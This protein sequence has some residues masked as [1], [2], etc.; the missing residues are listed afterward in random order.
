MPRKKGLRMVA[1]NGTSIENVG[2]TLIRFRGEE[3]K[4]GFKW[5]S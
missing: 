3:C 4:T 2:Q 5:R 1:A